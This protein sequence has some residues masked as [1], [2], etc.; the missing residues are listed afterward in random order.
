MKS[1]AAAYALLAVMAVMVLALEPESRTVQGVVV[2]A[3]A[4]VWT[5][6]VWVVIDI[7]FGDMA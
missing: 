3:V 2:L 7:C 5:V 1:L 6:V 4:V